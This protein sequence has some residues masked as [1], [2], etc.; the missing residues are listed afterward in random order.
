MV[1]ICL[2]RGRCERILHQAILLNTF[3]LPTRSNCK[4]ELFVVP[5]I[6]IQKNDFYFEFVRLYLGDS[7]PRYFE[8]S[9]VR[10]SVSWLHLVSPDHW[11]ILLIDQ[12]LCKESTIYI[13]FFRILQ[14]KKYQ[15]VCFRA[16]CQTNLIKYEHAARQLWHNLW[17]T[18]R[19]GKPLTAGCHSE[20]A[21]RGSWNA[22]RGVKGHGGFSWSHQSSLRAAAWQRSWRYRTWKTLAA[23]GQ[24]NLITPLTR[25]LD[26]RL[27]Y[28]FWIFT[29]HPKHSGLSG[30]LSLS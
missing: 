22:A 24:R 1:I 6:T 20:A 26:W 19:Q 10:L 15:K 7:R 9:W 12:S 13:C 23:N 2:V 25:M 17:L 3:C 29:F 30:Q 21:A 16:A 8:G 28:C 4:S 5:E 18:C 11:A 14:L 27:P